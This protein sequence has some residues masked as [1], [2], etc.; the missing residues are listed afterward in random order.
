MSARGPDDERSR[1]FEQ[2]ITERFHGLTGTTRSPQRGHTDM[3][4]SR[5][6]RRLR[7]PTPIN[8][9]PPREL[10]VRIGRIERE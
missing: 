6:L 4:D 7:S 8:L 1:S 2:R 5:K 10:G 9:Q 3:V